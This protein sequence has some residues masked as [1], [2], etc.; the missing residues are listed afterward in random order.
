MLEIGVVRIRQGTGQ[1]QPVTATVADRFGRR[2]DFL[3]N[4]GDARDEFDGRARLESAAQAPLLIDHRVHAARL[5]IHHDYCSRGITE[6]R[7]S[8]GADLHILAY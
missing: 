6:R 8:C 1:I 3:T 4:A 5:R 7:N 2:N